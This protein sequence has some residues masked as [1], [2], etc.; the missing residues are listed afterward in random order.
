MTTIT[1][2]DFKMKKIWKKYSYMDN[3][4]IKEKLWIELE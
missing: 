3:T 2:K 4:L 1:D